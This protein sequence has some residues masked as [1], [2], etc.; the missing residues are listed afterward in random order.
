MQ[1]ANVIRLQLQIT[2][3][4]QETPGFKGTSTR[5]VGSSP[6]RTEFIL[7][8]DVVNLSKDRSSITDAPIKKKPSVPVTLAESKALRE[9]FSVYA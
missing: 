5:P 1:S 7:P 8:E 6:R 4:H 9:S 2:P 3:A